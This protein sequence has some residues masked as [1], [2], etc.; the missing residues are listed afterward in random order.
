VDEKLDWTTDRRRTPRVDLLAEL[1]GHIVTLDEVV[2]VTQLSLG[3]MTV[4][5]TAPLSPKLLHDFRISFGSSTVM[6]H[7]RVVHSR[8][9]IRG[10]TIAY[11]AGIEFADP[12]PWVI[13]G[14]RRVIEDA[15]TTVE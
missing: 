2:Q 13:Q 6:V 7:G 12:A 14:I 5:T 1:Q 9:V 10:D 4:E 3:G 8:V 15:R 11:V